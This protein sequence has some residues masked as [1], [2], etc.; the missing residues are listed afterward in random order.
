MYYLR[1]F[2]RAINGY[3]GVT[4]HKTCIKVGYVAYRKVTLIIY[5]SFTAT[6]YVAVSVAIATTA[7]SAN[8][9]TLDG[10]FGISTNT[11]FLTTTIDALANGSGTVDSKG[12][13]IADCTEVFERHLSIYIVFPVTIGV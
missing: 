6:I 3:N 9:T 11:R 13:V 7:F 1:S 4:L 10:N 5:F 8:G 12:N 2:L